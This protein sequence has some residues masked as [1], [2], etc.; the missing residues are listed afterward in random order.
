MSDHRG[1]Q[2]AWA[3]HAVNVN[4]DGL[5]VCA[6]CGRVVSLTAPV[7]GWTRVK[8]VRVGPDGRHIHEG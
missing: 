3:I 2:F 7:A 5:Y 4:V 8:R 6:V 1:S